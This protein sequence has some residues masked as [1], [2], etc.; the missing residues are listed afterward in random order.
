[1]AGQNNKAREQRKGHPRQ[2]LIHLPS[3]SPLP[4]SSSG[5]PHLTGRETEALGFK[6]IPA[7]PH[8]S[9]EPT[10]GLLPVGQVQDVWFVSPPSSLQAPDPELISQ[11]LL[12]RTLRRWGKVQLHLP[13]HSLRLHSWQRVIKTGPRSPRE[14]EAEASLFPDAFPDRPLPPSAA[15]RSVCSGA[16]GCC[17][18]AAINYRSWGIFAPLSTPSCSY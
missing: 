5:Y 7:Q 9:P 12:Q 18:V 14:A 15:V 2:G 3:L 11:P 6:T 8:M 4:P 17:G 16:A 13:F 1:M 10:L